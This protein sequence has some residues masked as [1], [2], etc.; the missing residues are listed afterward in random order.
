MGL[1]RKKCQRVSLHSGKE[2]KQI[3]MTHSY[4]QPRFFLKV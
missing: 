2:G 1:S 3:Q 4:V